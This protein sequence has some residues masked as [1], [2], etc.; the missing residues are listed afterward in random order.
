MKFEALLALPD[1]LPVTP[2]FGLSEGQETEISESARA[3][4]NGVLKLFDR[5]G[6][7]FDK[8]F[9]IILDGLNR[10]ST[11]QIDMEEGSAQASEVWV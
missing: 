5:Y 10:A 3:S 4:K 2:R 1:A 6:A 9:A 11:C 8:Q 7:D